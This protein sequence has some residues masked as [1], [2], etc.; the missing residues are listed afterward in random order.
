MCLIK[1]VKGN[2]MMATQYNKVLS[3]IRLSW[4]IEVA[5]SCLNAWQMPV[6]AIS[7]INN[8]ALASHAT[9]KALLICFGV[10]G[11]IVVG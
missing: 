10:R 4:A 9:L 3:D 6:A 8:K 11:D 2:M 7:P 1:L 5:V